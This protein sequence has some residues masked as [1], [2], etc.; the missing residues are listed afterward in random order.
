MFDWQ[1]FSWISP[2]FFFFE[3]SQPFFQLGEG[4]INGN[5]YLFFY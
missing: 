5:A 1:F 2:W 4:I 3:K